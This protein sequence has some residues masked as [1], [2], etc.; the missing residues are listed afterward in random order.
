[1]TKRGYSQLDCSLRIAYELFPLNNYSVIWLHIEIAIFL[2]VM[3]FS[4]SLYDC[5]ITDDM[6]YPCHTISV[7]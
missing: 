2:R 1:M 6:N 3:L 7:V 4:R 5:H